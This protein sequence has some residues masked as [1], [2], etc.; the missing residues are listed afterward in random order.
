MARKVDVDWLGLVYPGMFEIPTHLWGEEKLLLFDLARQI[1]VGG[2]IVE[3]GSWLGASTCFL[4]AGASLRNSVVVAVDPWTNRLMQSDSRPDVYLEF[5][6]NTNP[7]KNWII[8]F[9]GL[10]LEAAEQWPES[11]AIDLFFLDGDHKAVEEDI[12]AWFPKMRSGGAVA[13]HDY[14]TKEWVRSVVDELV[15][16]VQI[17]E[18]HVVKSTYWTRIDYEAKQP[19]RLAID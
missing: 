6:I 5:L 15:P 14:G 19:D 13:F 16:P 2:I 17:E 9:R 7:L 8:P 3:V 1:P 12:G 10:S 18:G 4:A 11:K